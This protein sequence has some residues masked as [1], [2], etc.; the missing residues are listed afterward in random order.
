M[1]ATKVLTAANDA[2]EVQIPTDR[3]AVAGVQYGAGGAG[4]VVL[5]GTLD[6]TT[7]IVIEMVDPN[8]HTTFATSITA[9]GIWQADVSVFK[10]IRARYSVDG[11]S[12]TVTLSMNHN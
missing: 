6:D 4:T 2:I 8:D 3:L 11:G 7:W 9:A 10:K 1:I 5:E 12:V